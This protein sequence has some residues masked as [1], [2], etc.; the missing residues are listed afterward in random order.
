MPSN[1]SRVANF[2]R[3]RRRITNIGWM[4][5]IHWLRTRNVR[6]LNRK[7][8]AKSEELRGET[9]YRRPQRQKGHQDKNFRSTRMSAD[10][11]GL[12][13]AGMLGPFWNPTKDIRV[14]PRLVFQIFAP[15]VSL[16]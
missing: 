15:F 6:A 10:N 5:A 7:G 11:I 16:W 1:V 2:N 9:L 13:A 3:R 14:H 8:I 12:Y 4:L